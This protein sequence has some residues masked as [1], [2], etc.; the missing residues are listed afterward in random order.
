MS[1]RTFE[2]GFYPASRARDI[3]LG[4]GSSDNAV[5]AEINAL[6]TLVDAAARNGSLQVEIGES[7]GNETAFTDDT[8]G[9]IYREAFIG[10]DASF[11]ALFPNEEARTYRIRM[12]R[13]IGYFTR[14]GYGVRRVDQQA[15]IPTTFN[16]IIRW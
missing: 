9:P 1:L 7:E 14:L 5:L 12:E 3:A 10:T 8:T 15:A 2:D 4:N 6:Q 16:W 13:V 11:D